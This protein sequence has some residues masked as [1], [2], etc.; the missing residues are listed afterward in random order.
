MHCTIA[1]QTKKYGFQLRD[2]NAKRSDD[3]IV[4]GTNRRLQSFDAGARVRN[5][6]TEPRL[7]GRVAARQCVPSEQKTSLITSL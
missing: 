4:G 2:T 3:T 7:D 5:A 6:V 1:E